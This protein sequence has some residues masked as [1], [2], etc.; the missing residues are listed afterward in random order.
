MEK[1]IGGR[2]YAEQM[3]FIGVL[4]DIMRSQF[5]N[6]PVA[7]CYKLTINEGKSGMINEVIM[8]LRECAENFI[9]TFLPTNKDGLY[10]EETINTYAEEFRKFY[11]VSCS[12]PTD[13]S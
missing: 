6:T 2:S 1:D 8:H 3:V 5:N 4:F 13:H 7:A 9:K 12:Y 10:D 11:M